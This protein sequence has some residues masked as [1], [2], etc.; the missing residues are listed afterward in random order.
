MKLNDT[1]RREFLKTAAITTVAT[2]GGPYVKTAHSAGRLSLGIWDHWV[3]GANDVMTQLC[4]AWG[5]ANGVEV[6]IDYITSI[7][8]KNILTAAAEAR[9]KTGHD[10]VDLPTWQTT[11]HK[12]SLEPVDE[13]VKYLTDQYGPMTPD[14]EYLFNHDGVWRALPAPAGGNHGYPMVSRLDYFKKY[15]NV[16][17]KKIFP[18]GKNRDKSL[19][20][21]WN[22][23]N[24][25]GYARKLH[26]AGHPF[27][28][29]IGP[30]SDSQDWLCSLFLSFG[31]VAADKDGNIT[32]DSDGTR[33]ALEYTKK[34][35][36]YMPPDVYAW[37]DAGNNRW[38]I[39]GK[40]SAI[41]NP[42][43]AWTVAKRDQ[44]A[45]AAQ[46]WHH[47]VPRGPK[48]RYRGTLPRANGIWKFSKNKSAAK[49]L[50]A[51]LL[52]KQQQYKLISASQ[53]YDI[54]LFPAF[55]DHPIWEEI[56]PPVGGQYNYPIRGDE[57]TVVGGFPAPTNIATSIYTQALIPNM[58]AKVTKQERSVNQAIKWA[59]SELEAYK[60]R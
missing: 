45:V 4:N 36:Q 17:L 34:L 5:K 3:P 43:S 10:Y 21:T 55:F 14:A 12:E 29:P 50:L 25:L 28:N 23:E 35:T 15:V 33:A 30:T 51:H 59:E 32:I 20:E 1:T 27:G 26:A 7:G 18:A 58:V 40:G 42:P 57:V 6:K 16:D 46:L 48:G 8:Q 44:P 60:R 53:G 22:Y 47:D 9:A 54:P 11:I 24:F 52:E 2:V 31:S 37:D 38:I 13:V 19:V 56:G 39:S 49:D 41:Q